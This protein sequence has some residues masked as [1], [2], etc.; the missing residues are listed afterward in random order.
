M[1]LRITEAKLKEMDEL[2]PLGKTDIGDLWDMRQDWVDMKNEVDRLR[3]ENKR[4]ES[5]LD[6]A[7]GR[8]SIIQLEI[9]NA[10]DNGQFYD[11]GFNVDSVI[12][13]LELAI[14]RIKGEGTS[15]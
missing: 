7:V 2:T 10:W 5:Q 15:E 14:Q 1:K 8:M 4:L 9:Q 6:D 3:E 12:D 13:S 11:T